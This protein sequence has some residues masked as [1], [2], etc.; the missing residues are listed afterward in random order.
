[1]YDNAS[2]TPQAKLVNGKQYS[3]VADYL[4]TPVEAYNEAGSKVWHRELD[5][6]GQVRKGDSTF[7]PFLYQGQYSDEETGLAYNR[8]RYYDSEQGNYIS[9]DPIG[10][11]GQN[12]TFYCYTKDVNTEVDIYGLTPSLLFTSAD[13]LKLKVKNV[14]DLSHLSDKEIEKI[15]HANNN[16]KGRGLSPKNVKGETII[17]HHQKQSDLGP[18]IELPRS[19]HNLGNRKLH[20]YF[21]NPHPTNPVDRVRF[22]QWR[23]EYWK[24]RAEVELNKR[25]IKYN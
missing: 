2:F 14:Q 8:L 20:P 22:D 3:I 16:P 21:P 18:I 25:G 6:Y 24:N 17:L 23:K 13:G 19:A 1:V 10:L 12:P 5:C 4:G 15:Y 9:Q 7:I 11:K